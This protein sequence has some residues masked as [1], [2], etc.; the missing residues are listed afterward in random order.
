MGSGGE[1]THSWSRHTAALPVLTCRAG[2]L[3]TVPWVDRAVA[4]VFPRRP[5]DRGAPNRGGGADMEGGKRQTKRTGIV[6]CGG[7]RPCPG[8]AQISEPPPV[9][10]GWGS[11]QAV[12][13][14]PRLVCGGRCVGGSGKQ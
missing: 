12:G 7:F 3:S 5:L 8:V 4:F 9:G 13:G 2:P 11:V 10:G 14:S 6:L 1:A